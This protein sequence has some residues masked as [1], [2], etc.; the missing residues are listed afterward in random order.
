MEQND[1]F[2]TYERFETVSKKEAAALIGADNL[3]GDQF[4]ICFKTE[5]GVITAWLVNRFGAEIGYFSP[6]FSRQLSILHARNFTLVGLL[7]YVAFTSTPEPGH[8][9]GEVA[10]V[11]YSSALDR[12]A[13]SFIQAVG[14]KLQDG[15]RP[16]IALGA[17]GVNQ[18]QE[19]G[20]AWTPKQSLGPVA[21]EQNTVVLKDHRKLSE[22]AIEQGRKGN[23][24]C[25]IVS[26]AFLLALV[27]LLV[28]ALK[29]CGGF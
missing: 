5:D 1:Y 4:S 23:I 8:Y 16:D 24:G 26:W 13:P 18:M 3:V 9:W 17:Q 25:Y 12:V 28:F 6:S 14:Q 11:G 7:S 21:K 29:S 15:I 19:S 10:V 22:K 20:G 2:G 27:A